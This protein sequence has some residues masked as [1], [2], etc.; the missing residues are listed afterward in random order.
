LDGPFDTKE[1]N[2]FPPLRVKERS[3]HLPI[4]HAMDD[5]ECQ[6]PMFKPPIDEME[7]RLVDRAAPQ[8]KYW[9]DYHSDLLQMGVEQ[10]TY[11]NVYHLETLKQM[12]KAADTMAQM[13]HNFDLANRREALQNSEAR[14]THAID[15]RRQRVKLLD[16]RLVKVK[17]AMHL[18]TRK[19]NLN[20]DEQRKYTEFCRKKTL[21]EYHRLRHIAW[22]DRAL[23]RRHCKNMRL[24]AVES[25]LRPT[26]HRMHSSSSST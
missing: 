12:W 4:E 2:L 15:Q 26:M 9:F 22:L 10:D 14:L 13:K 11:N 5:F 6:P 17:R 25:M 18:L 19:Y 24:C 3:S 7:F 1:K 16:S 8:Y 20:Y 21:R 23:M